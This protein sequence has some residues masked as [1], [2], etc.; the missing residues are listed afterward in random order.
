MKYTGGIQGLQDELNVH[1]DGSMVSFNLALSSS[2][3]IGDGEE[4]DPNTNTNTYEGGGTYF[5]LLDDIIKIDQGDILI[6][7]SGLMHGGAKIT[8]G[9]RY[10][11]VGFMDFQMYNMNILLNLHRSFGKNAVCINVKTSFTENN[12][13]ETHD[14]GGDGDIKKE[15]K[16]EHNIVQNHGRRR[17]WGKRSIN[18][19]KEDT[20]VCEYNEKRSSSDKE[21]NKQQQH[22]QYYRNINK[23]VLVC[24]KG[25]QKLEIL[26]SFYYVKDRVWAILIFQEQLEILQEGNLPA[27]FIEVGMLIHVLLLMQVAFFLLRKLRARL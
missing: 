4:A 25:A 3:S 22:H 13:T 20:N 26:K 2:S 1:R 17:W 23:S 15:C 12:N 18:D 19:N 6:H 8:K 7:D 14:D 21:N 5:R 10:L 9:K 27:N 16:E 11:I 24:P